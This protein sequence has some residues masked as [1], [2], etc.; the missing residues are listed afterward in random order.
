MS[1]AT[2]QGCKELFQSL[3]LWNVLVEGV[4][5]A[6]VILLAQFQSLFLWN[7]LVED[8]ADQST[9]LRRMF[10]S[11]F[12]WNVLVEKIFRQCLWCPGL[13]SILVFME[14]ARRDMEFQR[15][16]VPARVSILVFMERAR[17]E[18]IER[19]MIAAFEFQSLFL[20]NVLVEFIQVNQAFFLPKFQSLFLWNVLVEYSPD[21][22]GRSGHNVS[23]LVFMERARR[24]FFDHKYSPLW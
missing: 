8:K 19:L 11:L 2:P 4:D 22:P 3:F 24:D 9:E 16:A 5:P 20:W 13:V 18:E 1:E 17:R 21:A 15:C 7:V 12:L 10:Q 23:I 14:R 6:V